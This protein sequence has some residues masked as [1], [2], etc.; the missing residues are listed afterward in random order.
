MLGS[1]R[2]VSLSAS[3]LQSWLLAGA[4]AALVLGVALRATA[5]PDLWW[6]LRTGQL[7]LERGSIP[8]AD[9]F[10]FTFPGAPWTNHEWL[11]EVVFALCFRIAGATGLTLL[12]VA[13]VAGTATML[14]WLLLRR[15]RNAFLAALVLTAYLP[16]L[17]R[18]LNV[19]AHAFTYLLTAVVFC[20]L[21]IGRERPRALWALPPLLALWANLHGGF[22]LGWLTAALGLIAISTGIEFPP[23]AVAIPPRRLWALL[24]LITA[25]P[26]LNPLGLRLVGYLWR[27]L[28]S[29][30]ATVSEWKSLTELPRL[31]P[32]FLM[33]IVP[34]IA[35]LLLA[36][37]RARLTETAL[38][39]ASV[40]LAYR[41]LRF[42]AL[43]AI[44]ASLVVATG[45]GEL[46]G[47]RRDAGHWPAWLE[48]NLAA[49]TLLALLALWAV[50]QFSLDVQRKGLALEVNPRNVP[51]LSTRFLSDHDLG[52]NLAT[53]LDWGGYALYHL[54]PRYRVSIDGRNVTV[55][56]QPF[57]AAQIAAY[58]GGDPLAGLAGRKVDVALVESMGPGFD[59]MARHPGWRLVFRDPLSAVF[60]PDATAAALEASGEPDRN[61]AF[62]GRVPTFP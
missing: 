20:V 47:R 56:P 45:L 2:P 25:A 54:W 40:F 3:R 41:H 52:P 7:I 60:V 4:A 17:S 24:A 39:L 12:R 42:L 31:W 57:V 26:L 22:V 11:S 53:R 38:F 5:D 36:P 19:R 6:H 30:H 51:I 50:P 28:G 37:A 16:L 1:P 44:F 49:S 18:L 46:R 8:K 29:D 58:D 9:P 61:Y 27:E 43:T 55:Y 13:I 62:S 48:G 35:L 14:A 34:A 10:S 32:A 21:E 15:T 59:G 23:R 33:L